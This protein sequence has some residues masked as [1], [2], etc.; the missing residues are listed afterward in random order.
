MKNCE[1]CQTDHRKCDWC[2]D[3][4]FNAG[5]SCTPCTDRW[6]H[7]SSCGTDAT[8]TPEVPA[9]FGCEDGW[10]LDESAPRGKATCKPAKKG[11]PKA[12]TW[13]SNA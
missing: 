2:T 9:C 8:E 4:F 12:K 6:D 11:A 7:C 3:G 1:A 10:E 5:D 13:S